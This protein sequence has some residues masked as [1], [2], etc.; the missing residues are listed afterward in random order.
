MLSSRDFYSEAS[1]G[2]IGGPVEHCVAMMK[3]LGA[4]AM[5]GVPDFNQST[6]AMGQ[7]LLN[8]PSVAGWAGGKAWI[9]PNLLI[10]RSGASR[11]TMMPDAS[12]LPRLELHRRRRRLMLGRR[13]RDGYDIG[14]TTVER[15]RS[16]HLRPRCALERDERFNTRISGYVSWQQAARQL[17]PT[18]Q[19][20]R[21]HRR[22]HGDD[23]RARGQQ[24]TWGGLPSWDGCCAFAGRRR[25]RARR[26]DVP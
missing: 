9:T 15:P 1:Q 2:H 16:E 18:P 25:P 26:R 24:P 6:I 4:P 20:G 10:A 19:A 12:R 14:A 11:A 3:H 21:P 13:L 5:P 22:R 7:H 23:T 8:P 17:I